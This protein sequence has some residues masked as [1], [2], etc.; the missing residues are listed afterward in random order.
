M[1]LRLQP[2][3]LSDEEAGLRRVLLRSL[4]QPHFRAAAAAG[5]RLPSPA[6]GNADTLPSVPSVNPRFV[7]IPGNLRSCAVLETLGLILGRATC[8]NQFVLLFLMSCLNV[9]IK[10]YPWGLVLVLYFKIPICANKKVTKP[11]QE[12]LKQK[13]YLITLEGSI[14]TLTLYCQ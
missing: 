6:K 10:S 11:F 3:L 14:Q 9:Q 2:H 13:L 12:K 8:R 5:R 1:R 4:L 7:I